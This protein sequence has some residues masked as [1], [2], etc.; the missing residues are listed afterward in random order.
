MLCYYLRHIDLHAVYEQLPSFEIFGSDSGLANIPWDFSN[1]L[2]MHFEERAESTLEHLYGHPM[3]WQELSPI[4]LAAEVGDYIEHDIEELENIC[5]T[6]APRAN[7][8]LS[9]E[10]W[11]DKFDDFV[12]D[13]LSRNI[14]NYYLIQSLL[15]YQ[16]DCLCWMHSRNDFDSVLGVFE[17]ITETT[18]MLSLCEMQTR[19]KAEKTREAQDRAALRHKETNQQKTTALA[20]WDEHGTN[21]SSMAAFAR[22]RCKDFGVTE[23]TLYGWIRD[24]RKTQL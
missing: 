9:T 3:P 11:K 15:I 8:R 23:R 20:T 12:L 21:V 10:K 22:S 14:S 17:G 6:K 1:R 5:S 24:H 13:V 4:D 19:Q 7:A 2:A 16:Y 18:Y